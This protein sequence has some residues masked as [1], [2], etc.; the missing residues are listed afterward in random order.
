MS[1]LIKDIEG[2]KFGQLTVIEFIGVEKKIGIWKCLC[3]CGNYKNIRYRDL[4]SG[5]STTCGCGKTKFKNQNKN[6]RGYGEIPKTLFSSMKKNAVKR[7]ILVGTDID[8]K[9]LWELY[10][11]QNGKCAISGLDIIFPNASLTRNTGTCSIDR[12]DSSIGY[13]DGN[14]QWV[15]KDINKMKMDFNQDVF[16]NYCRII[17]KNSK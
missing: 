14:I 1:R 4:R 10:L 3:D 9:Y 15:H 13:I 17:S 7:G 6:W 5:N 8:L 2:K 16:I 12:I 11:V